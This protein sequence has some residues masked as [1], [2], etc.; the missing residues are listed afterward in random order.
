MSINMLSSLRCE[1]R[2]KI[3]KASTN[4][5]YREWLRKKWKL[6]YCSISFHSY[7][8]EWNEKKTFG[9]SWNR[10][11]IC[12][13]ERETR[14]EK[15]KLFLLNAEKKTFLMLSLP[16][17]SSLSFDFFCMFHPQAKRSHDACFHLLLRVHRKM[18]LKWRQ[19]RNIFFH[20]FSLSA[21][22]T[23]KWVKLTESKSF[24]ALRLWLCRMYTIVVHVQSS[25]FSE[26]FRV[27][28]ETT[29]VQK[30]KICINFPLIER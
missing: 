4:E 1:W 29:A 23:T 15:K 25:K 13:Y 2:S 28:N 11:L 19:K 22:A 14:V 27:C 9:H 30:N 21:T 17:H 16:L 10:F 26:F 7:G 3:N 12:E 24:E 20:L 6:S 8:K 18:S 5:L